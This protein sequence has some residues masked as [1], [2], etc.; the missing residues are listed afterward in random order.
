MDRAN[1]QFKLMS[2][3]VRGL[4]N[5]TRQEDVKQV[6][7]NFRPRLF[8]FQETKL[9]VVDSTVIRN[10]A[11]PEYE[12]NYFFLSADATRGGGGHPDRIL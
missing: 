12:D 4:N 3:N 7:R 5:P 2:W 9:V 8:C 6:I 11:G 10:I 1:Q